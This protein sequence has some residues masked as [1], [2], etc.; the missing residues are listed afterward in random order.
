MTLIT[1]SVS[2]AIVGTINGKLIETPARTLREHITALETAANLLGLPA[3]SE[4]AGP[5]IDA[6]TARAHTHAHR[7]FI[8]CRHK[9]GGLVSSHLKAGSITDIGAK[10]WDAIHGVTLDEFLG[11]DFDTLRQQPWTCEL[12]RVNPMPVTVD[13]VLE[14][15][16]F[17]ISA[18]GVFEVNDLELV[19]A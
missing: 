1:P 10:Q 14:Y 7:W 15:A 5:R 6:R 16:N 4:D 11:G 19:V 17:V 18:G 3:F 9:D 8:D 12:L 13:T 2:L